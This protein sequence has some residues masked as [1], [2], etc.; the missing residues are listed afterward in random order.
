MVI[1]KYNIFLTAVTPKW[2]AGICLWPFGIY[3]KNPNNVTVFQRRH[4]MIHWQQQK[5]LLGILFYLLY[6]LEYLVKYF[7]YG[8]QAYY[9]ISFEREACANSYD[10]TYIHPFCGWIKYLIS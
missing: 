10:P 4:E 8:N 6:L 5:E 3:F 7:R 2:A 1:K 9:E